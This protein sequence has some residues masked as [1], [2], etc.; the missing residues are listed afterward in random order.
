[1]DSS[2]TP[3]SKLRPTG[4]TRVNSVLVWST[5]CKDLILIIANRFD[6]FGNSTGEIPDEPPNKLHLL[7]YSP[8]SNVIGWSKTSGLRQVRNYRK[9]GR[10]YSSG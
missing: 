6:P 3:E 7:R 9:K 2:W 4:L 5:E 1:V 8:T 10:S